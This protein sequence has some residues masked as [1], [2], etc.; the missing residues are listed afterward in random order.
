M[1]TVHHLNNS[2]S[3]RILWMLEEIG[4]PYDIK[5]YQRDADSNFAPPEL[6][7]VHPLGKSPV[8]TDK[9]VAVA[10]SGNIIDYL[11]REYAPELIPAV[12]TP[13]YREYSYWMHFA[14]GTLMPNLVMKLV[15]NI[16]ATG[17]MPFFARPIAKAI[18]GKVMSSYVQPN[19]DA[20][21]QLIEDHLNNKTWFCGKDLTGADFQMSFPLEAT[22]ARGGAESFP[23]I[24]DFVEQFQARP[25]Y[26]AA[27]KKGG[28]YDFAEPMS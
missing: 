1:V 5:I 11:S 13:A 22:V 27:L 15:F 21:L 2:R 6:K 9:G 24:K 4:A 20:N 18:A 8:V 19:I 17:P 25:A 10:E 23:R 14:E 3:Q 12:D 28:P 7:A 16:V 26:Q